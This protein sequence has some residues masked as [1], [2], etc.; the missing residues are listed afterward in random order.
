MHYADISIFE[1]ITQ[2]CIYV[3]KID[4]D[5]IVKYVESYN[6]Y[7]LNDVIYVSRIEEHD[8]THYVYINDHSS[9]LQSAPSLFISISPFLWDLLKTDLLQ[10]I[11]VMLGNVMVVQ[12]N[13]KL[14]KLPEQWKVMALYS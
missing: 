7:V 11:W 13:S 2:I 10:N 9:F 1:E 6:A 5:E 8:R 4:E 3:Y 12:K 14:L